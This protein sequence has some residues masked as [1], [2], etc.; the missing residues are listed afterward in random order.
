MHNKPDTFPA[1]DFIN[2]I[3]DIAYVLDA[4]ARLIFASNAFLDSLGMPDYPLKKNDSLQ[5]ILQTSKVLGVVEPQCMATILQ[6]HPSS[7]PD[8]NPSVH[9]LNIDNSQKPAAQSKTFSKTAYTINAISL[10]GGLT[11]YRYER[12]E[13]DNQM[14]PSF[15]RAMQINKT[16]FY[17]YDFAKKEYC[18]CDNLL[19]WFSQEQKNIVQKEGLYAL[20]SGHALRKTKQIIRQALALRSQNI[21]LKEIIGLRK[22]ECAV[23]KI[24]IDVKYNKAGNPLYALGIVQDV[25]EQENI[26]ASLRKQKSEADK[27]AQFRANQIANMSHELRTPIGGIVGMADVLLRENHDEKTMEKIRIIKESSDLL[28]YT[29]TETLDHCKL[30]ADG[31]TIKAGPVS[32]EALLKSICLLWGDKASENGTTISHKFSPDLPQFVSI[33]EFRIKQCLNNL[34]SNAVKFTKGGHIEISM[35]KYINK[36]G[37]TQLLFIV[38]D[39]GIGMT[40]KQQ[41]KIFKPFAQA[42]DNIE[43]TF[44]G[45]GLGMCITQKIIETMG[46]HIVIK[47]KKDIGTSIGISLPLQCATKPVRLI[48]EPN[49]NN[50]NVKLASPD[51]S[52][53]QIARR[54]T[55]I[56]ARGRRENI[57]IVDDIHTN[58]V[59]LEHLLS[60]IFPNLTFAENGQ[61][62]INV[63]DTKNIDIILMDVHM[64]ILN[65]VDATKAIRASNTPYKGIPIIAVTAD[66]KYHKRV[67]RQ[68]AGFDEV[69]AKPVSRVILLERI[70]TALAKPNLTETNLPPAYAIN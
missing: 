26:K 60:D 52:S 67:S 35:Q 41:D 68:G 27:S 47:S 21:E 69:V 66:E 8:E 14:M 56:P 24:H 18:F 70:D 4:E 51:Q 3:G 16:G 22:N 44:G 36:A 11:Y 31:V 37:K 12:N 63:L 62:A 48:A 2:K 58:R 33:D 13:A 20:M 65:G 34:L 40:D 38:K 50:S 7:T 30:M 59:I 28:M 6:L 53:R 64:P 46:G 5:D 10:G 25:S 43:K 49:N 1:V 57:L 42:N 15:H 61:E 39:S 17:K 29:L 55:I 32:P 54:P 23:L 9:L 45:T 19:D